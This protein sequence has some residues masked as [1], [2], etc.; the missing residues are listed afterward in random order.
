MRIFTPLPG[1]YIASALKR[2]NELLGIKSLSS[3]D[4]YIKPVPIRQ[5]GSSGSLE[6]VQAEWSVHSEFE[7]PSF[8]TKHKIAEDVLKKHTLYPLNAALGRFRAVTNI[9]PKKWTRI[10]PNCVLEDYENHGSA[11]IHSIHVE[12][13]VQVCSIHGS[14][15]LETCPHCSVPMR[16]HDITKLGDCGKKYKLFE[17][18]V[19]STAHLYSKFIAGLLDY[20]GKMVSRNVAEW[21]V[22]G[23]TWI[24]YSDEINFSLM[25]LNTAKIINRELALEVKYTNFGSLPD[26]LFPLSAFIGCVTAEKYLDLIVNEE[27]QKTLRINLRVIRGFH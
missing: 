10:C 12:R 27:S 23:S 26:H 14:S 17:R 2:G 24:K 9:T 15:L 16:K 25:H 3:K 19:N 18:H 21:I 4:F 8:L 13:S 11:F 1:E 7:F 22:H 6:T 20:R 5:F